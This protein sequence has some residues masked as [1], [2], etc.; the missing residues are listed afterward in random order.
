MRRR[1][2]QVNAGNHDGEVVEIERSVFPCKRV[3]TRDK[4]VH[5]SACRD[6]VKES[7]AVDRVRV[8]PITPTNESNHVVD[9]L[10][11]VAVCF[12]VPVP[13]ASH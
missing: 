9:S 12:Q 5:P 11:C 1:R 2:T 6:S 3:W 8:L 4:R 7:P 10:V 13:R